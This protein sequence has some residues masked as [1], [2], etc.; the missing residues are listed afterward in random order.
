MTTPNYRRVADE[1][2]RQI[3]SGEL[4]PGDQLPSIR[5]LINHYGVGNNAVHHA[6]VIL[7]EKRL[8]VGHQGKG[9]FV[10]NPD[11]MG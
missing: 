6:M 5:Q 1:L 9:V 4:A 2:Q 3:A 10:T 8:V 7:K 11:P